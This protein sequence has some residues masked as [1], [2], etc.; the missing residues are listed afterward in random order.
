[1]LR[2]DPGPGHPESP[3]RLEAVLE[4]LTREGLLPELDVAEPDAA[5]PERLGSVHPA[6]YREAIGRAETGGRAALDP[7]TIVGPGSYRAALL[8]AGAALEAA[9]RVGTGRS[10]AAFCAVRPPGHH[11]ERSRAM[12]FCLLNNAALAARRLQERGR[13]RVAIVDWDVHHGNGTQRIFEE[14]GSVLFLSV[15]QHPLYPGTGAA[16]ERGRG[17]GEGETRNV[18]L[19]AGCGNREYDAVFRDVFAPEV[20]RFR[21]DAVV[22]S[23]GFD[24]HRRDPLAGM[25]VD[26]SGFA[27]MTRA[28]REWADESCEGRIVSLLEGG[29]DL[30]A[31]ATSVEAHLG[32]LLR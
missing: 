18:P 25:E 8:A 6:A 9:D 2:H 5:D 21:P 13:G 17:A 22:V 28:V 23:A 26:A 11:A 3:R 20:R 1:M 16:S 14:D 7:D 27:A 31:L 29:Y 12:G 32:E 19:P 15:H 4:R 30:E 10:R 24:A